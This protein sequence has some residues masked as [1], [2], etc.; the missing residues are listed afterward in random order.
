IM[1]RLNIQVLVRPATGKS[2][3]PTVITGELM[4]LIAKNPDN[5]VETLSAQ[6]RSF[7]E[8]AF[9]RHQEL[10]AYIRKAYRVGEEIS[11]QMS[12]SEGRLILGF[13]DGS[14][15]EGEI[16]AIGSYSAEKATWEWAWNNPNLPEHVK[17]AVLTAYEYGEK[18][19][20]LY[21]TSGIVPT[22]DEAF[23]TYLS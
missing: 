22:R 2:L 3:Y 8:T 21:L 15:V 1:E 18:E 12:L 17:W 9:R 11:C 19:G 5:L 23:A 6:A 20:I 13:E 7:F 4:D 14:T 16:Q 10:S